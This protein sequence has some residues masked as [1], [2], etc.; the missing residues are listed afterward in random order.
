MGFWIVILRDVWFSFDLCWD[1]MC[2]TFLNVAACFCAQV[3]DFT[4]Q[5]FD[6]FS[7][8]GSYLFYIMCRCVILFDVQVFDWT[9]LTKRTYLQSHKW[10][11]AFLSERAHSTLLH[12]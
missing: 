2:F 3:F 9:K 11:D 10:S 4:L 1:L 12:H 8:A 5:V 7:C 6:S